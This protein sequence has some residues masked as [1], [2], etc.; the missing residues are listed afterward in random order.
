M[1]ADEED[2]QHDETTRPGAH[3]DGSVSLSWEIG[4]DWQ[5]GWQGWG[6]WEGAPENP[7]NPPVAGQWQSGTKNWGWKTW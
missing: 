6:R 3:N 7:S 1:K 2:I 4:G 5:S